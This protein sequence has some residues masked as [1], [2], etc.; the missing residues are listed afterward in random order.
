ML[1]SVLGKSMNL[2]GK[3]LAEIF[4]EEGDL[5]SERYGNQDSEDLMKEMKISDLET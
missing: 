2:G 4:L 3:C 5:V 1:C